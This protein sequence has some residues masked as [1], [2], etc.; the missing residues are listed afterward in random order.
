MS[1]YN[2]N[3]CLNSIHSTVENF[4]DKLS[5]VEKCKIHP[6]AKQYISG[7]CE[8]CEAIKLNK[9]LKKDRR[10]MLN[11]LLLTHKTQI[12]VQSKYLN[13]T[14]DNYLI[15]NNFQRE[16]V[17]ILK[18]Y[19]CNKN[20]LFLGSTGTGKTH[21]SCALLHKMLLDEEN[22]DKN[23]NDEPKRIYLKYLP[24]YKLIDLKTESKEEFN[25]ILKTRLLILD[26]VFAFKNDYNS[27]LLYQVLAERYA[28]NKH[29]FIISNLD[30]DNFVKNVGDTLFSRLA[31]NCQVLIANWEDYRT[32]DK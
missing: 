14:F 25:N 15:T 27:N 12:G 30:L 28:N 18:Q 31:E 2:I 29:T 9:E 6:L 13:S 4:R 3:D 22:Y 32:K 17:N 5:K 11:N 26:E 24:F 21:L 10:T 19:D 8:E 1:N 7:L 20:I 23:F 16:T